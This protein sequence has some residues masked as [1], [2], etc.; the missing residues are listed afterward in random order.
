MQQIQPTGWFTGFYRTQFESAQDLTSASMEGFERI[1]QLAMQAVRQQFDDQ[2]R[3]VDAMASRSAQVIVDPEFARPAIERII[4]VQRQMAD[5]VMQTNQ[6]V[7]SAVSSSAQRTAE[8]GASLAVL[9][10]HRAEAE[11]YPTMFH[12]ALQQWQQMA[13]RMLDVF[14]E[15]L[16]TVSEEAQRQGERALQAAGDIAQR[17]ATET[18]RVQAQGQ[19]RGSKT[20][21]R[22]HEMA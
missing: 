12:A 10:E 20:T 17:A 19:S 6:R 5:A 8:Q 7:L 2:L 13:N 1:Q 3:L 14:Q 4:D 15:Q 11:G 16:A 9:P 21:E 18:E 22:K